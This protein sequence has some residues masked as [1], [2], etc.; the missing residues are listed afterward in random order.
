MTKV[1]NYMEK[2][3]ASLAAATTAST[4]RER[5]FHHRAHCIWRRLV[6]DAEFAQNNPEAAAKRPVKTR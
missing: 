5:A 4:E 2:A 3:A 1:E 6:A